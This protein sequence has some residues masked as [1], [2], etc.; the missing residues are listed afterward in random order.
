M[1][2]AEN[3]RKKNIKYLW[4]NNILWKTIM[5]QIA[6]GSEQALGE[7]AEWI[8]PIEKGY[9]NLRKGKD[10][11]NI[12]HVSPPCKERKKKHQ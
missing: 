12:I 2:R 6:M 1:V 5:A 4:K 3:K 8:L 10:M 7:I 11:V 9:I